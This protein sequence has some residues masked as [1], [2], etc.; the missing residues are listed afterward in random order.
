MKTMLTPTVV[1]GALL[2]QYEAAAPALVPLE[3]DVRCGPLLPGASL[4]AR[5]RFL[6]LRDGVHRIERLMLTGMGDEFD[7]A[8]SPVLEVVVAQKPQ[9]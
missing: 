8:I 2:A 1:L 9:D 4:A 3:T 5:I 6:A 7:F